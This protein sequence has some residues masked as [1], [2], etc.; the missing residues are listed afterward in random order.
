MRILTRLLIRAHLGPFLFAL[1]ALTGLLFLNAVAQRMADLAGKGLAWDVIVEFLILSL[2]HT[3]ALTLPMAVLVAVLHAFT[4]MTAA[5]EITAMKAGGI[6]PRRILVP[7][8]I[9]GTLIGGLMLFFNDRVLP[10]ANHRLKNLMVDINRKS[11]TFALREQ[12]VNRVDAGVTGKTFF[13][14]AARID[15]AANRMEDVSIVDGSDLVRRRITYADSA[16][17]AF[18]EARTD[19][20]LTLHDGV[21]LELDLDRPGGFQKLFFDRQ[22]LPLRGVGN[23]MDRRL[24]ATNRGDREMTLAMLSAEADRR[25]LDMVRLGEE[26]RVETVENVRLALGMAP[27]DEV[28]AEYEGRLG[29]EA[30][31]LPRTQAVSSDPVTQR[32][33]A[34]TAA[35]VTRTEAS[36][37]AMWRHQ[38]EYHKKYSLAFA[39]FVFVLLGIPL[40]I[41]YPR[42]G[43]GLVI[44]ASSA[45]FAVYWVGLIAGED[46]AERGLAPPWVTMWAPN[47]IFLTLGLIM[48]QRMGREAATMRGGGWDD[49]WWTL[50]K[51][52][53]RERDAA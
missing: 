38:V 25:A 23:E 15:N 37:Q 12:V 10:E 43:L 51:P 22:I 33:A 11:P 52:F 17:M 41:R 49:L 46:V 44:A 6:A 47:M 21:L 40:G 36:R 8:L 39:C 29:P 7:L 16:F 32:L 31:P 2:P 20:F 13:I 1:S 45:I 42:G 28:G 4:E 26:N 30:R 35:N 9:A 3:V 50:S 48:V 24:D 53:R 18:N 14:K 19:L 27:G 5:N 34:L